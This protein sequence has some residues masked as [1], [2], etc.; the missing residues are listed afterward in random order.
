[1]LKISL[2]FKKFTKTSRENNSRILW[3]KNEKF[4]GHCFHVNANIQEDFQTALVY[5]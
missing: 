4:P 1:M 5:L 2:H 3:N